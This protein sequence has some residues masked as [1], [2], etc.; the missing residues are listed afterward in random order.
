V[1]PDYRSWTTLYIRTVYGATV[2]TGGQDIIKAH[3]TCFK[4]AEKEEANING[5]RA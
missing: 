5:G 3:D 4:T 1:H 2:V